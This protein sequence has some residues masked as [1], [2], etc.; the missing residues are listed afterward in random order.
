MVATILA[1]IGFITAVLYYLFVKLFPA[2]GVNSLRA[3]KVS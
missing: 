3:W 2:Q 1:A